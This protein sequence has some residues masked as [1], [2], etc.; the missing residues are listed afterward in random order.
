MITYG[1]INV[2]LSDRAIWEV[3]FLIIVSVLL[4]SNV[5]RIFFQTD[6]R[7]LTK[8]L[9]LSFYYTKKSKFDLPD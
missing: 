4:P 2:T 8:C 3:S 9:L 5:N 7:K 6:L 1:V